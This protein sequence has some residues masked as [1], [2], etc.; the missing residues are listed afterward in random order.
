MMMDRIKAAVS[1]Y[2]QHDRAAIIPKRDSKVFN[3][4]IIAVAIY[5]IYLIISQQLRN[6]TYAVIFFTDWIAFIINGFMTLCLFYGASQSRKISRN[7]FLAWLMMAI[8]QLCFTLG[9]GLWAWME[10]FKS[11]T[12]HPAASSGACSRRLPSFEI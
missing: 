1:S 4:T 9:D 10:T 12:A 11:Q 2:Y 8:G 3:F 7:V 5:T 6:D